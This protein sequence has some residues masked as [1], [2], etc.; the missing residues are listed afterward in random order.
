MLRLIALVLPI[1][2]TISLSLTAQK[3]E[4]ERRISIDSLPSQMLLFLEKEYPEKRKEKYYQEQNEEGTFYEAKF[5]FNDFL[6][7]VKFYPD[8]RLYDTER[9]IKFAAIPKTLRRRMTQV[10]EEQLLRSRVVKVQ[11]IL[12]AGK[13]TGYEVEVK[14]K[15]KEHIGYFELTFNAEGRLETLETIEQRPNDFLFF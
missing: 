14:G 10:L 12:E 4:I 1:S 15:S 13:L 5:D 2:L 6:Y 11:E 9:K 7:S 3:I 8:G